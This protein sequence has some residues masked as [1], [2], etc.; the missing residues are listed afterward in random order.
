MH[1]EQPR[2]A[3]GVIDLPTCASAEQVLRGASHHGVLDA[4]SAHAVYDQSPAA[5]LTGLEA[6]GGHPLTASLR[7]GLLLR[8]DDEPIACHRGWEPMLA[9]WQ[10]LCWEKLHT[11][12]WK[13]VSA[14]H[15]IPAP[16]AP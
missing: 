8:G 3:T 13:D 15:A 1:V 4:R 14:P 2:H 12:N 7:T 11:G 5:P 9:A 10:T 16:V 6:A